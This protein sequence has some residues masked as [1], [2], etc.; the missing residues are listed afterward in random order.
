M[1]TAK[2]YK[3]IAKSNLKGSYW[4][5]FLVSLIVTGLTTAIAAIPVIGTIASVLATPFL[6]IGM[7][8]WFIAL[9]AGETKPFGILF[10]AGKTNYV[11]ALCTYLLQTLY[12]ALWSLLFVIPGLV[13]SYSYAMAMYLRAKKPE[14]GANEAI[15]L[16]RE[17]MN[18]R[19]WKLFCLHFSFIGWFILCILTFGLGFI[20]LKPYIDAANVTFYEDAYK[21]HFGAEVA[22]QPVSSPVETTEA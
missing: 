10:E 5:A 9:S 19:K 12:L 7:F 16:S 21:A 8:A 18:G 22:A 13:K 14:L 15:T 11:K 20:F 1:K 3:G 2:E 6:L 17:I 4:N